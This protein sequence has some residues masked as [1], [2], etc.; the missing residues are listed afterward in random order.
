[1]SH[2]WIKAAAGR[3]YKKQSKVCSFIFA[4]NFTRFSHLLPVNIA[5]CYGNHC[6]LPNKTGQEGSDPERGPM[7]PEM[8]LK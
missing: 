8:Q 2:T 4:V 1:M 3:T 5:R 6:R 7:N